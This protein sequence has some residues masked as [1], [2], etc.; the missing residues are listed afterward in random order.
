MSIKLIA[1]LGNPGSRYDNTRH[2]AGFWLLDALA[3]RESLSFRQE[4]KFSGE[5]C[6]F[7]DCWLLKPQTFM[8]RS[9]QA[10]AALA[11]FYKISP[12]QILVAHDELDLPAGTVRLKNAGGHG[13]H[14]GLRDTISQLGGSKAFWRLRL[15]IGHPGNKSA[16]VNYVLHEPS[17]T[18]RSDIDQVIDL[19]LDNLTMIVNGDF[20]R[21][22]NVLHSNS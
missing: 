3:K 7:G 14:N 15:G 6:R 10:I 21:A 5:A 9:G 11:N 2:N 22:M 16:V 12:E 1:G 4:S 8:N 20:E 17:K 19:S 13:G 18:E